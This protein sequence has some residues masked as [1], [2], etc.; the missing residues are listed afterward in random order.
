[1][2]ILPLGLCARRMAVLL[3]GVAAL[4]VAAALLAAK[5]LLWCA[6]IPALIPLLT[7]AVIFS[8]RAP[9]KN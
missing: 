2:R 7:P 5:P 1:M 8:Y 4:D 6:R 9:S 3:C